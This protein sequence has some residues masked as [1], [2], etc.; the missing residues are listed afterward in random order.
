VVVDFYT[1][2]CPPCRALSPV[3]E[4]WEREA[5]GSLKVVKVD[6][7]AEIELAAAYRVQAVPALFLFSNGKCVGQMMGLQ[8]RSALQRWFSELLTAA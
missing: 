4:Q 3:L 8:S 6:A 2:G 5:G 7:A 1:D